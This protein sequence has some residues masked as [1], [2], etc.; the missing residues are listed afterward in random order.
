MRLAA[1]ENQPDLVRLRD[2]FGSR[3]IVAHAPTL[4]EICG[5]PHRET[6]YSRILAF[7]LD[8]TGAHEFEQLFLHALMSV[9]ENK[10]TESESIDLSIETE[11]STNSI[12]CEAVTDAG[13]RIDI[14]IELAEV[15]ICIE[16]KINADLYND[17]LHYQT[18]CEKLA[19]GRGKQFRGIVLAPRSM[20][21]KTLENSD[22]VSVTYGELADRVRSLLGE[23]IHRHNT[24]YQ[25]LLFDFLEQCERLERENTMTDEMIEFIEFWSENQNTIDYVIERYNEVQKRLKDKVSDFQMIVNDELDNGRNR[26]I[27][28]VFQKPKLTSRTC[29]FDSIW[30]QESVEHWSNRRLY[31]DVRFSALDVKFIL[32]HGQNAD[33]V[34]LTKVIEGLRINYQM[35]FTRKSNREYELKYGEDQ[36]LGCP[37][38]H[39]HYSSAFNLTHRILSAITTEVKNPRLTN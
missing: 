23:Y 3:E 11:E 1:T 36:T 12:Q 30:Y 14:L 39:E 13:K 26:E 19:V 8:G 33:E 17:L 22:F 16:N 18:Y 34:L 27:L 6:V 37:L 25:Y 5:F 7:L 31:L 20:A 4:L 24:K 2:K 35:D 21:K 32:A 28:A 15:V 38:K 9:Y 29:H 10:N